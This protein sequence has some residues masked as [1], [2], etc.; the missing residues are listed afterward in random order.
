MDGGVSST[1]E[2]EVK[3]K[4]GI[5]IYRLVEGVCKSNEDATAELPSYLLEGVTKVGAFGLVRYATGE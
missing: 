3:V 1:L 5:W 2:D 4:S